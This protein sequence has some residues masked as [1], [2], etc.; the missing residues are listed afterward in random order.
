MFE[1]K[2]LAKIDRASDE[3]AAK[4]L[5]DAAEQMRL[6]HYGEEDRS[7]RQLKRLA[8]VFSEEKRQFTAWQTV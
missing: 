5:A 3:K 8:L 6:K 4:L 7:G 2:F 1:L